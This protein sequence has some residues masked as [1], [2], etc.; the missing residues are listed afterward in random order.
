MGPAGEGGSEG[1][2]DNVD[3]L[4]PQSDARAQSFAPAVKSSED[5]KY[6]KL[7]FTKISI[8]GLLAWPAQAGKD[9]VFRFVIK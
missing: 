8:H 1:A 3:A 2:G 6:L 5:Q 4:L 7:E 9:I